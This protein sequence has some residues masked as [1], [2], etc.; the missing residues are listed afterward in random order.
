LKAIHE[1]SGSKEPFSD[2]LSWEIG[3]P[4]KELEAAI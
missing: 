1:K 2:W 3:K 4:L